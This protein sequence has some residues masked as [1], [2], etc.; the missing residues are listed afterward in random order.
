MC[1]WSSYVCSSELILEDVR[2]LG[3]IGEAVPMRSLAAHLRVGQHFGPRIHC[4]RMASDPT[5]GEASVGKAGARIVGAA[6][7][8][9]GCPHCV[10][11]LLVRDL[12]HRRPRS[13][14]HTSELQSIMRN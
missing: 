3:E 5:A 11:G 14:E 1:V 10:A 9:I 12:G 4:H 6:R 2:R 7:T 8:K 13:E